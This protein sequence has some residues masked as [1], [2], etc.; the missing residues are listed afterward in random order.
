MI[1]RS[2]KSTYNLGILAKALRMSVHENKW[3]FKEH[4]TILNITTAFGGEKLCT[5]YSVD[6]YRIDLYFPGCKI[7][8]EC[9]EFGHRERDIEYGVKRRKYIEEKPCHCKISKR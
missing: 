6:G 1:N 3:L 2:R 9:D 4:E 5:Q 7:A 8:F